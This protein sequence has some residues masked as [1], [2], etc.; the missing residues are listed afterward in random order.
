MLRTNLCSKKYS[1]SLQLN[2]VEQSCSKHNEHVHVMHTCTQ[3]ATNYHKVY[4]TLYIGIAMVFVFSLYIR[5]F[6][7]GL[8]WFLYSPYT[9]HTNCDTI[10]FID[11]YTVETDSCM[12]IMLDYSAP[13]LPAPYNT[14]HH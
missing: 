1:L 7:L 3:Y 13:P 9:I 10:T 12:Y 5:K 14:T 4:S 8:P 11:R 2:A 6:S